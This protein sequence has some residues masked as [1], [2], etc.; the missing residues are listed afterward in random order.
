MSD[1]GDPSLE[2]DGESDKTAVSIG[3]SRTAYRP[4]VQD[5]YVCVCVCV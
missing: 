2:Y 3:C 5:R 1:L 4:R